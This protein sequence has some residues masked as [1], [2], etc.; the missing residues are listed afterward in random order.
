MWMCLLALIVVFVTPSPLSGAEEQSEGVVGSDEIGRALTRGPVVRPKFDAQGYTT[1][2]TSNYVSMDS[3]LFDLGS[4]RLRPGSAKQ[5]DEVVAALKRLAPR[6]VEAQSGASL[7]RS[8]PSTT[9]R[10]DILPTLSTKAKSSTLPRVSS[11]AK[12][13]MSAPIT[14]EATSEPLCLPHRMKTKS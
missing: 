2:E 5:L 3:I 13:C 6:Q 10:M 4:D 8:L 12:A 11:G 1:P 7:P 14:Q 9:E